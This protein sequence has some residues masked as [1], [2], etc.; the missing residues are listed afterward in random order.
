MS[1]LQIEIPP[2][3][4]AISLTTAKN[5]LRVTTDN[6]DALIAMMIV[7]ARELAET[8]TSRSIVPKGYVQT[9]DSFPYFTDS[10]S[11]QQ[12]YPPAY[13]SLPRYS[14]TMWNY[15]S[16]IKLYAPPLIQIV[17]FN[18]ID[19]TNTLQTLNSSQ[20]ILDNISE[21]ARLFPGP[22]GA[23]W[24]SV[25]YVPNSVQIHFT[26]GYNGNS[27]TPPMPNGILVAMMMLISNWFENRD[28]AM[29]G[30]FGEV[31]NH[32]RALLYANRVMDMQPT[33]G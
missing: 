17:A 3:A 12:A 4:E 28:A 11:S 13:Y 6:D 30:N 26:A 7:A 2:I 33:R 32:V 18:Y 16:M 14:T 8:I 29:Q 21:P 20:Y 10:I 23:N 24:P 27:L 15:S 9:M 5:Y 25:L 19:T 31:P 22:A 1:G